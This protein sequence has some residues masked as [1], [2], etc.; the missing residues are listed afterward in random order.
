MAKITNLGIL[1]PVKKHKLE[2]WTIIQ[3]MF[4]LIL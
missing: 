1:I 4:M 2:I 3:S